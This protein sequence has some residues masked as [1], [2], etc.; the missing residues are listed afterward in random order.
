VAIG[1]SNDDDLGTTDTIQTA[2]DRQA[3]A[4]RRLIDKDK[5][6]VVLTFSDGCS[7]SLCQIFG[8]DDLLRIHLL[9]IVVLSL[10]L[11]LQR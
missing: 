6:A 11:M 4:L 9:L 5:S 3:A 2:D 7:E 1:G 10:F 8:N